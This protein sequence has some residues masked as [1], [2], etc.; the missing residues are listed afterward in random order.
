MLKG[1]RVEGVDEVDDIEAIV[2]R[3]IVVECGMTADGK[4]QSYIC[5]LHHIE[6]S[7]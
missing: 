1:C 3:R 6:R 5:I 4:Y 2:E 7:S